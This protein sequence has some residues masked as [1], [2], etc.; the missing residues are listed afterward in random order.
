MCLIRKCKILSNNKAIRYKQKRQLKE[1]KE[2]PTLTKTEFKRWR[3]SPS[4]EKRILSEIQSEF[5]RLLGRGKTRSI[6]EPRKSKRIDEAIES[7]MSKEKKDLS[8]HGLALNEYGLEVKAPTGHKSITF[9][10]T[11]D[12]KRRSTKK[13]ICIVLPRPVTPK[14]E[15]PAISEEKRTQRV[16]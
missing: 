12:E 1:T 2:F 14:N 10:E 9:P 8:S 16:Q 7:V 13:P 5:I 3:Y 6:E 15:E 4:Y 11:S